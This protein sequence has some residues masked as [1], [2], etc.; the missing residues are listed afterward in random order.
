MDALRIWQ[1]NKKFTYIIN[2]NF[3]GAIP[4]RTGS[5]LYPAFKAKSDKASQCV[6]SSRLCSREKC[7]PSELT[8]V[9]PTEVTIISA[10]GENQRG[11]PLIERKIITDGA[12]MIFASVLFFE[13]SNN[14]WPGFGWYAIYPS[15]SA[16][17]KNIGFVIFPD[18]NLPDFAGP[19]AM[20]EEDLGA[21]VAANVARK[22]VRCRPR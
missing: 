17:M 15:K 2:W 10:G 8:L 21:E 19:L 4:C 20:I 3:L 6:M 9:P 18:V 1:G 14:S 7:W 16:I 13:L 22:P 12:D 11:N 5:F